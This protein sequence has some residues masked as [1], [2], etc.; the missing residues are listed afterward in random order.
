V[1]TARAVSDKNEAVGVDKLHSS[2]RFKERRG[3]TRRSTGGAGSRE[4]IGSIY[5][6]I[7]SRVDSISSGGSGPTHCPRPTYGSALSIEIETG[8]RE[9]PSTEPD[10]E[11]D[12]LYEKARDGLSSA[13]T[14]AA[15]KVSGEFSS[16]AI[17]PR[18]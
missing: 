2:E 14:S 18:N 4:V 16:S 6:L 17:M 1:Q 9:L 13:R 3:L 8:R 12:T 7:D 10:Q 15:A 5:V 11:A